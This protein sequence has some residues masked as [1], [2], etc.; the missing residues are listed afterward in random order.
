MTVTDSQY[1]PFLHDFDE[2]LERAIE[3]ARQRMEQNPHNALG[4][5]ARDEWEALVEKRRTSKP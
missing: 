2:A 5:S 1:Q 4:R 3:D